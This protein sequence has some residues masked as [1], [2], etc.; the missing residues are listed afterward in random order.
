MRRANFKINYIVLFL[1]AGFSRIL[2]AFWLPNMFGDAYVYIRD[3]GAIS[4]KLKAG[5]FVL[6]DLYGFW[7]PFYQ[8]VCAVINVFIGNGFYVGKI[9]SAIFGAGV[10][11]LVY[12]ITFQI[13]N[14]RTAA[15]LAFG[16]IAFNPLHIA[17]SASAMTD[18]PHAFFV[19]ASLL[20]VLRRRWVVAA[21]FAAL[22]GFTRVESW[23]LIAL[24]PLIQFWKERRVSYDAIVIMLT[25][26]LFWFY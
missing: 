16:L 4:T 5:T 17:N 12:A 6:N 13:V 9:V 14:H 11:V 25:A 22:A 1:I 7:L 19:M 24:I 8:F 15:L 10:C 21:V 26:P 18:I 20:F 2:S 3:I 23:M